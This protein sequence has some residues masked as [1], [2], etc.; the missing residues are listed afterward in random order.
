MSA[1]L[2]LPFT[3]VN[4]T[5]QPIPLPGEEPY[6][7]LAA[8][9]LHVCGLLANGSAVCIGQN[10]DGQLGTVS[11]W[12][13]SDQPWTSSPSIVYGGGAYTALSASSNATCGLLANGSAQCWV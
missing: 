12:Y 4:S 2:T 11:P 3:T 13:V 5:I 10:S 6:I 8:G 7:S 9:D 1:G